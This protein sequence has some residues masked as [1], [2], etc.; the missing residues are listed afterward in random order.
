MNTMVSGISVLKL[1]LQQVL[2]EYTSINVL[3][4]L[5]L[6]LIQCT[7]INYKP[8]HAYIIQLHIYIHMHT[9][10]H[11]S[12]YVDMH[13]RIAVQVYMIFCLLMEGGM[14]R[15]YRIVRVM[16]HPNINIA[17]ICFVTNYGKL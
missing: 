13:T 9:R 6:L 1:I 3:S 16:L 11:A 2:A 14:V 17:N 12:I 7:Y 15:V 8:I 5:T 10:M 4:P